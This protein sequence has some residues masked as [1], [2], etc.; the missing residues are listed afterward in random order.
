MKPGGEVNFQ[1]IYYQQAW[2][3]P[4]RLLKWIIVSEMAKQDILSLSNMKIILKKWK[5]MRLREASVFGRLFAFSLTASSILLSSI[6]PNK[7]QQMQSCCPFLHG[8]TSNGEMCFTVIMQSPWRDNY[9]MQSWFFTLREWATSLL[10]PLKSDWPC[11]PL[12]EQNNLYLH[13]ER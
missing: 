5:Y 4:Q 12:N 10:T 6:L 13:S 7:P 8:N 1:N 2:W 11:W 9:I 3:F